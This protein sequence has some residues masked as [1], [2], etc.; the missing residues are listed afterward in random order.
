M[1]EAAAETHTAA[2]VSLLVMQPLA[3]PQCRVV[4]HET[5]SSAQLPPPAKRLFRSAL[6]TEDA[7]VPLTTFTRSVVCV[8]QGQESQLFPYDTATGRFEFLRV[9]VPELCSCWSRTH[10]HF[11]IKLHSTLFVLL[12]W[13][14]CQRAR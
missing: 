2:G 9:N 7:V 12:W 4:R 13:W 6:S 10:F 1:T 3:V 5:L 14:Q 8:L 11:P